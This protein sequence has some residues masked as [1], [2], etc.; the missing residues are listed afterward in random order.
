MKAVRMTAAG[1][2][3]ELHDVA[4]REPGPG[5]VL[6]RVRAA[7]ICHSDAHYRRGLSPMGPL[8][9]T[10]GHEI[11]GVVERLGRGV[12][13][14]AVGDRVCLHYIVTC[15]MCG[16]CVDGHEGLCDQS[17]MLGHHVDGGFA[18]FVTVRA[19]SAV[20]LPEAISF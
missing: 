12:R 18:E 6:V 13:T 16:P 20:Q 8:P 15:G 14:H 11:A 9:L 3:L 5:E 1:R 17:A 19:T 4:P 7:G 2:P 10:L